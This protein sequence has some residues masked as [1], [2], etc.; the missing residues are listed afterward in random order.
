MSSCAEQ[1]GQPH[2][3]N[4]GAGQLGHASP[5]PVAE[6]CMHRRGNTSGHLDSAWNLTLRQTHKSTSPGVVAQDR[7]LDSVPDAGSGKPSRSPDLASSPT[8]LG[9]QD[10][11]MSPQPCQSSKSASRS[12]L[13]HGLPPRSTSM[14]PGTAYPADGKEGSGQNRGMKA[15]WSGQP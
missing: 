4:S 1:P 12:N 6:P 2:H 8:Q 7:Q 10:A 3:K 5:S 9:N 11:S 14:T 15:D 13:C